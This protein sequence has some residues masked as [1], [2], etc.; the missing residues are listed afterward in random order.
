VTGQHRATQRHEPLAA[1]PK[2]PDAALRAWL[3][4]YAKDHPRRG[5]RP[6]YHDARGEYS[7]VN[8]TKVQRFAGGGLAGATAATTQTPRCLNRAGP[9]PPHVLW[10]QRDIFM[11][12]FGGR[13][14]YTGRESLDK[15]ATNPTAAPGAKVGVPPIKAAGD[16]PCDR[17]DH[18]RAVGRL[19]FGC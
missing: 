15:I 3:H 2:D 12:A 19:P 9:E 16:G 8:H 13:D 11:A 10:L 1:T 14:L 4:Q 18:H 5:F 17:T 7:A 6:T